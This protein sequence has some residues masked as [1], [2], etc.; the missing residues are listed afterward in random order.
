[1]PL[2]QTFA[3]SWSRA[4]LMW[5]DRPFLVWES[6]AGQVTQWSY[7]AF[8]RLVDRI[9]GT[10]HAA[11]AG[12]QAGVHLAL[13]NSP[14]FVAI[15]LAAVR[16]GSFVIPCD[17]HAAAPEIAH[18]LQR[19]KPAVGVASMRRLEDYRQ[20]ASVKIEM[21]SLDED[22]VAL[23][24]FDGSAPTALEDPA[25][26]DTAAIMFTS[27]TTSTPKGV[28]ITQANYAPRT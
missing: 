17:P 23:E 11:G 16:L 12:P 8:D 13:T 22:D 3:H 21:F 4:V 9:A 20:G 2:E 18:Q 1:M 19:T 25:L 14:A 7:A 15:W 24:M 5:P 26:L 27:G 28:V 10:L 6:S